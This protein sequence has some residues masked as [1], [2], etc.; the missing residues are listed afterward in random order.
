MPVTQA[1]C[2]ALSLKA[3]GSLSWEREQPSHSRSCTAA[4]T[5]AGSREGHGCTQK[6]ST[7]T[8]LSLLPL[9]LS[10]HTLLWFLWVPTVVSKFSK[11][12]IFPPPPQL[13]I[14]EIALS[15]DKVQRWHRST[16]LGS[17]SKVH[18]SLQ[19]GCPSPHF[20]RTKQLMLSPSPTLLTLS[21]RCSR[22]E[23]CKQSLIGKMGRE[24]TWIFLPLVRTAHP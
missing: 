11:A 17:S 18:I 10:P 14:L 15:E 8:P 24:G 7:R 3:Q 9:M 6:E 23:E 12:F 13:V 5:S 1:A 16:S 4:S 21:S 20:L 19:A 22:G 2:D